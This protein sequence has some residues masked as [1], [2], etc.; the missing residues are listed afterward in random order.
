MRVAMASGCI[1]YI[2]E[3]LTD[4]LYV[5]KKKN[6]VELVRKC[7]NFFV[8]LIQTNSI[9]KG[10]TNHKEIINLVLIARK[11]LKRNYDIFHLMLNFEEVG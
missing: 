1:E 7:I 8:E 6:V 3:A 11:I 10:A 4:L 5:E 2:I 9:S